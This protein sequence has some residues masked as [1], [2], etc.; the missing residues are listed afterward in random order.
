MSLNQD[1]HVSLPLNVGYGLKRKN[2]C[3]WKILQHALRIVQQTVKALHVV[4]KSLFKISENVQYSVEEPYMGGNETLHIAARSLITLLRDEL[5]FL[6]RPAWDLV[7]HLVLT[8]G[9]YYRNPRNCRYAAAQ[10]FH[11]CQSAACPDHCFLL[12]HS[13]LN[14][15]LCILTQVWLPV[16]LLAKRWAANFNFCQGLL[17]ILKERLS[18]I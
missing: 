2:N 14:K 1:H 8:A 16:Q 4:A 12:H 13:S 10:S 11:V 7:A 6:A 18:C 9:V 3:S 17:D 5:Y 15:D